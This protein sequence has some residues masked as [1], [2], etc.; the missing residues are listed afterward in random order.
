M[1][2]YGDLWE[3]YMSGGIGET[4]WHETSWVGGSP[5]VVWSVCERTW[6]M[7]DVG[8]PACVL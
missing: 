2:S 6:V 1:W 8:A 3:R 4:V 5:C 7:C